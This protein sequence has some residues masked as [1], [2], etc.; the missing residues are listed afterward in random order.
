[1][2][3]IIIKNRKYTSRDGQIQIPINCHKFYG[4]VLVI[5]YHAKSLLGAGATST[6]ICQFQFHTAFLA[7]E[8][9]PNGQYRLTK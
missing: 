8:L 5:L 1:M 4:D 7:A 2:I 9:A 3:I 6:R